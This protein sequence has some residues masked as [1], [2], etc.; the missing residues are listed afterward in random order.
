MGEYKLIDLDQM[1]ASVVRRRLGYKADDH[2]LT[3]LLTALRLEKCLL[4]VQTRRP[5]CETNVYPL[6]YYWAHHRA[7][8]HKEVYDRV[9]DSLP[10]GKV[11]VL[12]DQLRTHVASVVDN[13]IDLLVEDIDYFVFIE[14][15]F[16]KQDHNAKFEPG[17]VHQLVRQYVQ[18]RIL[19][20]IT[21]K[22]FTLATIGANN[23]QPIDLRLSERERVLLRLV[24][25]E[26]EQLRVIDLAWP[27]ILAA[28]SEA[29]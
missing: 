12:E 29:E 1:E 4:N 16:P 24:N 7:V 15:K 8:T 10:T 2:A 19:E 3:L 6:Y 23:G 14:A 11:A 20:A 9:F 25:E 18:G 21:N 5:R 27:P 17:V 13:E 28:A 22:T 26:R